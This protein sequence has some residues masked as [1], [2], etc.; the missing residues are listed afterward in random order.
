MPCLACG[1]EGRTEAAHTGSDGGMSM[2]A[3]DYS[4]VPLCADRHWQAPGAY[5]RIGK[6]AFERARDVCLA[7]LVARLQQEWRGKCA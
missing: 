2:K 5:H 3:S 6:R 7:D 4:V 1:I